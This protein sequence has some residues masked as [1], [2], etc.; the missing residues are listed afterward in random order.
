MK[1]RPAVVAVCCWLGLSAGPGVAMPQQPPVRDDG[2]GALLQRVEQLMTGGNPDAYF[3][4]LGTYADRASAT[5]AS[6]LLV[7]PTMTRTVLRE[8]DRAPLEGTLPGDGYRL[9]VEAFIEYGD[10]ARVS[11]WRFDV[12]RVGDD[13]TADSWVIVGQQQ[14][15]AVD[16][17]YRL[18]LNSTRQY[19]VQNL[20]LRSEDLEI[21]MPSGRMFISDTQEG[22]T[23][24]V[25]LPGGGA[26]FTFKPTPATEREQVKL[27]TGSEVITDEFSTVFLRLNA[28][29]FGELFPPSAVQ[30]EGVDGGALKR[31]ESVFREDVGKS[32]SLDMGDLSRDSWSLSPNSGDLLAEIRT[33]QFQTLTYAKSSGDP[34]DIS[35]FDRRRRKNISVY[36]SR[37]RVTDRG[38]FFDEDESAAYDITDYHVETRFEPERNHLEGRTRLRLNVRDSALS[39]LTLKLADS[40]TVRSVFSPDLGRLLFLRVRNQH[41]LVVNLP[42]IATPGAELALDIEYGGPLQPSMVEREAVSV[43]QSQQQDPFVSDLLG[44]PGEPSWLYTTRTYWYPQSSVSDYAPALLRLTVPDGYSV[45]ASGELM[46]GFPVSVAPPAG[47]RNPDRQFVFTA[48]QPVRYLSC[49]ITRFVRVGARTVSVDAALTTV[50]P[51]GSRESVRPVRPGVFYDTLRLSVDANPRLRARGIR[52]L[53][54]AEDVVR[55]YARLVG[56]SPYPSLAVGLIEKELPGGH[57]PAYLSVVHQPMPQVGFSW[58]ND[59]S[60]FQNYPEFFVAH[61]IAHQWWGQAVGW[62]S[63]HEQ[64]ISEGFSQYFAALYARHSRGEQAFNDVMRRMARFAREQSPQGPISLGYRLGHVR[65]DSRVFR[66][67]VYNKSA[68]VLHNLRLLLGDEV[69]WR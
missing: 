64:W 62:R 27:F 4:L 55:F 3:E 43:G 50:G 6:R 30:L 8:R 49:L 42:G 14:I 5:A 51:D 47:R 12:R 15:S 7:S 53:D 37:E 21:R 67:L 41:S 24:V 34:E 17:L 31:A 63:Y 68:V 40:L 48:P 56:D 45:L 38:R 54:T 16:G 10:R 13:N 66:S 18:S 25:L 69:F 33:R 58:G 59:P 57:S 11:T 26:T 9:M 28:L 1:W 20:V 23:A 39:S 46:T 60:A 2:I 65:N 35:V 19:R 32:F 36:S 22:P 52:L 44:I 29:D 61:E